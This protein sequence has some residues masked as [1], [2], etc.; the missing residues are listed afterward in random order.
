MVVD[1]LLHRGL[2]FEAKSDERVVSE[3]ML[4]SSL[5][6]ADTLLVEQNRSEGER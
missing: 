4:V 1:F 2:I 3:K 5:V 6:N